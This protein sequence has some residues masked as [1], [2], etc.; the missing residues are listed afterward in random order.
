ME[1]KNGAHSLIHR[2]Y[3]HLHHERT[4]EHQAKVPLY[5]TKITSRLSAETLARARLRGII[6]YGEAH[7]AAVGRSLQDVKATQAIYYITSPP[8]RSDPETPNFLMKTLAS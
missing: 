2:T 4:I 5:V 6:A 1:K 7:T 3:N 8:L